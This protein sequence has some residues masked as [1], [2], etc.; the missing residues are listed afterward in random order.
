MASGHYK[1]HQEKSVGRR[2]R[3]FR[4]DI[5]SLYHRQLDVDVV[6]NPKAN[7]AYAFQVQYAVVLGLKILI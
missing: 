3:G 1:V 2:V 4:P 7:L 5:E 6:A